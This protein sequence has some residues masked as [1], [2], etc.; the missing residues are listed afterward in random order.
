MLRNPFVLLRARPPG[1]ASAAICWRDEEGTFLICCGVKPERDCTRIA[2]NPLVSSESESLVK[3]TV[4]PFVALREADTQTWAVQPMTRFS[5][6]FRVSSMEGS[7]LA[8]FCTRSLER[9]MGSEREVNSV[10]MRSRLAGGAEGWASTAGA[11][12][13]FVV[14]ET[15]C[16]T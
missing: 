15:G 8:Y 11:A 12:A 16:L 4:P 7:C 13:D 6:V 3:L 9:S 10:M 5:L 14:A 1:E 2:H